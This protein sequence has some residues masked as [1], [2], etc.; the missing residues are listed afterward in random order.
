LDTG[1]LLNFALW[2][3]LAST[4]PLLVFASGIDALDEWR[5]RFSFGPVLDHGGGFYCKISIVGFVSQR[6]SSLDWSSRVSF[7]SE[8][9]R[10]R[11]GWRAASG[12]FVFQQALDGQSTPTPDLGSLA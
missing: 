10:W 6:D 7:T 11:R 3:T 4:F 5:Q 1:D 8:P 9:L 12:V 2:S